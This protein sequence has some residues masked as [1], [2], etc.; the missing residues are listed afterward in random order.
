MDAQYAFIEGDPSRQED[1]E[2]FYYRFVSTIECLV[3]LLVLHL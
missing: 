2:L 3:L 1:L